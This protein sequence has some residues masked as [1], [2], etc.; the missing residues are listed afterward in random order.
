MTVGGRVPAGGL[1]TGSGT[2][3]NRIA[4]RPGTAALAAVVPALPSPSSGVA[5][6]GQRP[7]VTSYF[8]VTGGVRYGLAS[9]GAAAVLGYDLATEQTLVPASVVDLIPQ[10]PALDPAAARARVSG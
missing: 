1:A 4:M 6:S 8:L 3:V 9:P 2:Y 7:D 5:A 10:G